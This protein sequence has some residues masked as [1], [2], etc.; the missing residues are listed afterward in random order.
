MYFSQSAW[1]TTFLLLL[2]A[3]KQGSHAYHDA[4]KC[5]QDFGND[6]AG[7]GECFRGFQGGPY[8]LCFNDTAIEVFQECMDA[9]P[10]E[11][12][13]WECGGVMMCAFD[14]YLAESN[15]Y[16]ESLGGFDACVKDTV[17]EFMQCGMTNMDGCHSACHDVYSEDVATL[18]PS[19]TASSVSACDAFQAEVADA[20]CSPTAC[21]ATCQAKLDSVLECISNTVYQLSCDLTCSG[22]VSTQGT[23]HLQLRSAF[24]QA[25][26][27]TDHTANGELRLAAPRHLQE[28]ETLDV[29]VANE[30]GNN[31]VNSTTLDALATTPA[32]FMD[33]VALHYLWM[34]TDEGMTYVLGE[35]DAVAGDDAT[36]TDAPEPEDNNSE[37]EVAPE[38]NNSE[39]EVAPEDEVVVDTADTSGAVVS[40]YWPM[41]A[42]LMTFASAFL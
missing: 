34:F 42:L 16:I 32:L 12:D 23:R 41:T 39:D 20:T 8:A 28:E 7:I 26:Q 37:D 35:D 27:A 11:A 4:D 6:T 25:V 18:F 13:A 5:L 40:F 17:L 30:C 19:M 33:C 9:N 31:L 14:T 1:G 29:H 2:V 3:S 15:A 10:G 24:L 22:D 36:G 38:D 21:C